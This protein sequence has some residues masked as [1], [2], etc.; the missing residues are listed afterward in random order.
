MKIFV[1]VWVLPE[2]DP[3]E[4]FK[5]KQLRLEGEG[6]TWKG[7]GESPRGHATKP[8]PTAGNGDFIL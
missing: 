7:G 8:G 3:E 5:C 2:V 1:F 4:G 6:S